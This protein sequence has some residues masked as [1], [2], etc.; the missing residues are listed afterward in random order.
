MAVT[1]AAAAAELSPT[2]R[3]SRNAVILFDLENFKIGW[4]THYRTMLSYFDVCALINKMEETYAFNV[5]S[6]KF[7]ATA[8]VSINE[9]VIKQKQEL[10]DRFDLS[11]PTTNLGRLQL[12]SVN[13]VA[14]AY[15]REIRAYSRLLNALRR[16]QT[17]T[18][19][20]NLDDFYSNQNRNSD[21]WFL[22][23]GGHE[24]DERKCK[25]TLQE[26]ELKWHEGRRIQ[27][28]CDASIV[29]DIVSIAE[30]GAVDSVVLMSGD[31]DFIQSMQQCKLRS[32]K[33]EENLIRTIGPKSF[34][35]C[36]YLSS[37]PVDIKKLFSIHSGESNIMSPEGIEY[38]RL[39]KAFPEINPQC[40]N[41]QLVEDAWLKR[42]PV[43]PGFY[44]SD[45]T[46]R[47]LA[48]GSFHG[49]AID[50]E[51]VSNYRAT[52]KRIENWEQGNAGKP[53][54]NIGKLKGSDL[55]RTWPEAETIRTISPP[56]RSESSG[57]GPA[58]S[59]SRQKRERSRSSPYSRVPTEIGTTCI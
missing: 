27:K 3:G 11:S 10:K 30:H 28:G 33:S 23:L 41:H 40:P 59:D 8:E 38:C 26:F 37:F 48:N 58:R 55:L 13:R 56:V 6:I 1:S 7:Y 19:D 57:G 18:E 43:P 24:E 45:Y 15:Q 4:Q 31:S 22:R 50:G 47:Q 16:D 25:I 9:R 36:S 46:M 32:D 51:V 39:E 53:S 35:M 34:S 54:Y 49:Y 2:M 17:E 14:K 21:N 12:L 52:S 5:V 42:S 29:M 44:E 20:L